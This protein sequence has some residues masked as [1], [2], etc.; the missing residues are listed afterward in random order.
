M[1]K[2]QASSGVLGAAR[3]FIGRAALIALGWFMGVLL[4][5]ELFAVWIVSVGGLS[6]AS[7]RYREYFHEHL[8]LAPLL[9]I[10]DSGTS[11]ESDHFFA[12]PTLYVFAS[13]AALT[14]IVA[15]LALSWGCFT[16]PIRQD[17][18]R[19]FW[20]L[21][22]LWVSS[23]IS[24]IFYYVSLLSALSFSRGKWD[25][26]LTRV[27]EGVKES[28]WDQA[29][30]LDLIFYPLSIEAIH[31]GTHHFARL[32]AVAIGWG[33]AGCYLLVLA[34]MRKSHGRLAEPNL[35]GDSCEES[36]TLSEG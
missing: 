12:N 3:S 2:S 34:R 24:L 20:I 22:P 19:H 21:V 36:V 33:L 15:I 23:S 4:L 17:K 6:L 16:W 35:N 18:C 27:R 25:A 5:L 26:N 29:S 7:H 32:V 9:G 13:A 14:A 28:F 31:L 8:E 10:Y 11:E 30:A 1:A